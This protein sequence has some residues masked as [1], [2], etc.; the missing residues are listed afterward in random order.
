[1]PTAL[2]DLAR[3][4]PQIPVVIAPLANDLGQG[5]IL[6]AVEEPGF[7]TLTVHPDGS[8]T[9]V[10]AEGFSGEDGFSYTLRDAAGATAQGRV[11][12][13]VAPANRPPAAN[14]DEA[15]TAPGSPVDIP[16]LANDTDPDGDPLHLVALDMPGH[17]SVAVTPQQTLRY[18]PARGFTGTDRFTYRVGDGRGGFAYATVTVTVAGA[19]RPPTAGA[20]AT[21]TRP[22]LPVELDLF[23]HAQ[24]PEGGPLTLTGLG[25]PAHGRLETGSRG[26][27]T[28]TPDPGF[29]G[30]DGFSWT[31]ADEAGGTATGTALIAVE[32]LNAPPVAVDDLAVTEAGTPV[33]IDLLAN[34][35]DPEG[36]PLALVA[37]GLPAH[38]SLLLGGGGQVTYTPEAGFT[39]EDQFSYTLRDPKGATARGTVRVTVEEPAVPSAWLNG[40]ARRR[41]LVVPAGRSSERLEGFPLLLE[42]EG[43]WLRPQELG[44]G[45]ADAAGR[46]LRFELADGTRL[47]HDV[48][49]WDPQ[50]G[51]LRAWVRLPVLPAGED[52]ELFCYYGKAGLLADEADP[53]SVWRDH[54]A[55]WHLPGAGDRSGRG[56]DLAGTAPVPAE[57]AF[58]PAGRFDGTASELLLADPSFLDGH[59]ALAV[60]LWLDSERLDSD[61]GIL[62]VGAVT[63]R[64]A[65]CGLVLRH[66]DAGFY[67]GAPRCFTIELALADG[68][69]IHESASGRAGLEAR[70][71]LLVWRRGQGTSLYL[72]GVLDSA[73]HLT[74]AGLLGPTRPGPGPL[75]LGNGPRQAQ[76]GKW[77]G[78]LGGVRLAARAP[79]AARIAALARNLREPQAFAALGAEEVFGAGGGGPVAM[80]L[81][82]RL[83][84]GLPALLDPL[85]AARD[86]QGASLLVVRPPAQ[87]TAA[88]VTGE[89]GRQLLQVTPP[90]GF[91]GRLDLLFALERDG[92]RSEAVAL[93]EVDAAEAPAPEPADQPFAGRLHGN[94]YMCDTVSEVQFYPGR[95]AAKRIVA[96][97]SGELTALRWHNRYQNVAG[98][99]GYSSGDGGKV[100]VRVESDAGGLPSG[101]VL[102]ETA[103]NG[104]AGAPVSQ[105]FFPQWRFLA[106][107]PLEAGRAYHLVWYQVGSSGTVSVDF[108]YA[109]SPIPY[110]QELHGGPFEGDRQP[111][112]RRRSDGSWERRAEH[113]GFL[114]LSWADGLV[115]GCP[116]VF[117]SGGFRKDLGG[118]V[119]ARQSFTLRGS[120]RMAEGVWLRAWWTDG[121][122]SPLLLRL[123][124]LESGLI[125]QL[126]L[127]RSAL[128]RTA[129]SLTWMGDPASPPA[130]WRYHAFAA[131][132]LL[133]ADRRYALRLSCASGSYRVHAVQQADPRAHGSRSRERWE[134]AVAEVSL[135]GGRT[136]R[137]WDDTK[138]APG[139]ARQDCLLPLAFALALPGTPPPPAPPPP[140]G[141][142]DPRLMAHRNLVRSA[143]HRDY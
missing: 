104:G 129:N 102:G 88:I 81:E 26:R 134:E 131:P 41:L 127:P 141:G 59:D 22:G 30:E 92:S 13:E 142:G 105:G 51:R 79:S 40:Y 2:P 97:R 117:S 124:D 16:V 120:P 57:G 67:G 70:H 78:L 83:A 118:S 39:G 69:L 121:A 93:L 45:L 31:V 37:L 74:G 98:A 113:G 122:P 128:P 64:D 110:G 56:R 138:E 115:T 101:E 137:G 66:N 68:R 5:L 6:A 55:V 132:R 89:D 94:P 116:V 46:D 126:E 10:P 20:L 103:V 91:L 32:T 85:A 52:L 139:V 106:P 7:G 12:V 27:V 8:L 47:F 90:A 35:L 48:E 130:S 33:S 99:S 73:S 25:V 84:P 80:P 23:A 140:D 72:D 38:G 63:G 100:V 36:G 65:D 21:A 34:D 114:E 71:L 125:E 86:A 96:E 136:W 29:E 11:T 60:E 53:A 28:Y 77:Q 4:A 87:G 43:D 15:R 19:D 107:V 54:L 3:T 123:E 24:D 1:M 143:A 109:Y 9:Y 18:L 111:V 82:A 108:H 44:G 76:S 49:R 75:R 62:A 42:A 135:D 61:Q 133:A 17:G 50:A 95:P 119:M 58:G 14:G 112:L